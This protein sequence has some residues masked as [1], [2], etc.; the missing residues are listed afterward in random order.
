MQRDDDSEPP[1]SAYMSDEA[2]VRASVSAPIGPVK[3]PQDR[4]SSPPQ[5]IVRDW[6]GRAIATI[7]L[8]AALTSLA[9]NTWRNESTES[10]RNIRQSCFIILEESAALQQIIEIRFYGDD[11][12]K[13]TW[14]AAW[15]KASLI[16]DL[17]MLAP[18]RTGQEAQNVFDVWSKRSQGI[19][20]RDPLAED[21]MSDA[22]ERLRRQTLDDLR[23]LD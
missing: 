20:A 4:P 11:R 3:T 7:S 9:Y 2:P 12:S 1:V 14:I 13:S 15:G 5:R 22:I 21:E 10:H 18:P 16:R 23:E 6:S 19:D 17:G 8:V